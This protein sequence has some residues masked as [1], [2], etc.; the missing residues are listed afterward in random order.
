MAGELIFFGWRRPGIYNL[1]EGVDGSE[2]VLALALQERDGAE[3]REHGLPLSLLGPD[4]VVGLQPGAVTRTSPP[5]SANGV[6]VTKCVYAEF[7][8]PDL[9]WRYSQESP[10]QT[11]EESALRP[12]LVLV[13]GT[14][15]E[16][17]PQPDG[18]V[19][20]TRSL[21]NA[22][23]LT[24]SARWAHVQEENGIIVSRL[25][26][27]R[28]LAPNQSYYAAIVRVGTSWP[29]KIGD[30]TTPLP[31]FYFW[32]F[33]TG[34]QDDFR[35]LASRLK[36]G[37]ADNEL[38]QAKVSYRRILNSPQ[39]TV[40]G[41]L[42]SASPP[43]S[44]SDDDLEEISNDISSLFAPPTDNRG[45]PIIGLPLYG[46]AWVES[47][48]AGVW[49]TEVNR[50]PRH[51][52]VA[53]LG[54]W[55]GI[56][57]QEMISGAAIDQAGALDIAAQR[58][59]NFAFGLQANTSLWERRLPTDL[60]QRLLL[61]GPSLSRIVTDKGPVLNQIAG[62]VR[63]LPPNIFSSAARRVLR[64]GALKNL[65][66][67]TATL[68]SNL[69]RNANTCPALDNPNPD[70]LPHFDSAP[71]VIDSVDPDQATRECISF[72]KNAPG[73]FISN[74][75]IEKEV[76]FVVKDEQGNPLT[77]TRIGTWE[78]D[79]NKVTDD[80]IGLVFGKQMEIILPEIASRV[81][82]T[83]MHKITPVVIVA[84]NEDQTEA[85]TLGTPTP[86]ME[87]QVFAI[88]G[89]AIKRVVLTAHIS[90]GV[91]TYLHDFCFTKAAGP[92][93]RLDELIQRA[94]NNDRINHRPLLDRLNELIA[95]PPIDPKIG[96]PKSPRLL[97]EIRD[98]FSAPELGLPT[99]NILDL[100][101]LF[102]NDDGTF[103]KKAREFLDSTSKRKPDDESILKLAKSFLAGPSDRQCHPVDL[104]SLASELTHSINPTLPES[105]VRRRALAGISGLGTLP[106]LPPEI[107]PGLDMPTWQ[108]LRDRAPDWLLPGLD[109]IAPDSVIGLE[110]NPE[111]IDA[112]LLGINTQ[113]LNELRWRN[114]RIASKCTPIKMFWGQLDRL[115]QKREPDIRG[116]EVWPDSKLGSPEH[117]T[118]A[119]QGGNFVLLIRGEL[120]R[121]YPATLVYLVPAGELPDWTTP[122]DVDANGR[123]PPVFQGSAGDDITFFRFDIISSEARKY[124]VVL[125]E[126]PKG[127]S[128]FNDLNFDL[129]RNI[130]FDC[131]QLVDEKAIEKCKKDIAYAKAQGGRK[132][133]IA[134]FADPLR[135]FIRGES[136]I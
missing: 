123:K 41:A 53:G 116:I 24:K 86:M 83:I 23:D 81:E 96:T 102:L 89:K 98:K 97:I 113:T 63:P 6:E 80:K 19:T 66:I 117:Q 8:A 90:F 48:D 52:A 37:V 31:L 122:P 51:R 105:F 50:D 42:V 15:D 108:F 20:L 77:E 115:G 70:G 84:I 129:T 9:P 76:K 120:F 1:P 69:L 93:T 59:R 103:A 57:L 85:G 22:Y 92:A 107:C 54:M 104:E 119:S 132:F 74:P 134:A 95:N 56:E 11:A 3:R 62:G 112:F 38:G 46:D 88:T 28:G 99:K 5:A 17:F 131:E 7:A 75:V 78:D 127:Y 68:P 72:R 101:D 79:P 65:A 124:W 39:F 133:A 12:W 87:P 125:E 136:I 94:I 33:Q 13:V 40:R 29:L 26:S 100:I 71:G 45:R 44:S 49:G 47:P 121:R 128:F 118:P 18:T 32:Q 35:S 111:F 114:I 61:F 34:D 25:L 55:A 43:T 16:L 64:S 27:S 91:E 21:C 36:P 14:P 109:R 67:P 58:I 2:R 130:N 73:R 10:L 60:Y 30:H 126:T 82:L 135:V 106:V 4:D 110:T